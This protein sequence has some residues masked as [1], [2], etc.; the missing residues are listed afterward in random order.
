MKRICVYC[1]SSDKA[2]DIYKNSATEV[3][4]ILVE[5]GYEVVYGGGS[6]GLMGALADSVLKN[7]GKITGVLPHFMEELEWGHPGVDMIN[8]AD[9]HERKKTMLE[10][11]DGVVALAGGC[12]TLEEILEAITWK[13]LGL[14]SGPAVIVNTNNYYTPLIEQ[15]N[16]AVD[17]SFMNE[18]HRSLWSEISSTDGLLEALKNHKELKNPL[19]KAAVR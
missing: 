17:E 8:V 1:A 4:K 2:A 7:D 12:G 13:R 18:E 19:E 10:M 6:I 9:M 14:F 15:L 5:N 3:A 11:A 16:L